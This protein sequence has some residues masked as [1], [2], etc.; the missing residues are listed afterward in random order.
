MMR[1]VLALAAYASPYLTR[2]QTAA[3]GQPPDDSP[4]SPRD[5]AQVVIAEVV[6][7]S[8]SHR[9]LLPLRIGKAKHAAFVVAKED[10][11]AVS[12]HL[13]AREDGDLPSASRD[14]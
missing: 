9:A 7:E 4:R 3:P 6:G 10:V 13:R 12:G 8:D 2:A 14:V 11:I 1:A 5:E